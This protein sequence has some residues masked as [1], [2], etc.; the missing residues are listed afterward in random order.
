[1]H[2]QKHSA[3]PVFGFIIILA[4]VMSFPSTS[5][6]ASNAYMKI[7]GDV[8]G[9][10]EGDVT[11]QG[12]EG[13][14]EVVS[15]GHNIVAPRDAASGLPTGKRQHK[16]VRILKPIDRSSPLLF[17]AMVSNEQLEEVTIRFWK[18][19]R[20]GQEV[21]FYTV[22]LLNASIVGIMPIHSSA[23]A[24]ALKVPM[25]ESISFTY[26]KI[27]VTFEDGGITAEDDWA[28]PIN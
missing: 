18:P 4:V 21:Q 19:S 2:T 13:Q 10:I 22:E 15:F 25:R 28:A 16:P 11:Q 12:R 5:Q 7:I 9:L 8:Q 27:I 26:E 23:N 24:E 3:F 20:T 1:M 17:L 6:A 14:I